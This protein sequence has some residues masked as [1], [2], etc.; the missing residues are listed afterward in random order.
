MIVNV[1]SDSG[2]ICPAL[3]SPEEHMGEDDAK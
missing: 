3:C 2:L 1:V